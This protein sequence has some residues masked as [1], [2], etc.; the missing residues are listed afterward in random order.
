M[1]LIPIHD[2]Q[3]PRVADYANIRE[4]R[5]AH[6]RGVFIAEGVEVVR[7]LVLKSHFGAQSL[8]VLEK[9]LGAIADVMGAL[10]E[11]TPVYVASAEVMNQVVGFNIHRGCLAAGSRACTPSP[12][13]L[14]QGLGQQSLVVV[15]EGLANHDNVGG[16]F[17]N[18]A[19]FGA[20]AIFLDPTCADPL[21][22]KSIRTSMGGT[23]RVPFARLY[24]WPDALQQLTERG[25]TTYALSPRSDARSLDAL[26]AP[27]EP[28]PPR[29]ALLVGTEGPGLS[30]AAFGACSDWL[31]IP[32]APGVDSLNASTATGIA[33]WALRPR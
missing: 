1:M 29:R 12:Q 33:L 18:A 19:C 7:T 30:E 4:S 5:L 25:Y 14:L 9:R 11:E 13:S 8:F 16:I 22:R 10:P 17:R 3:D 28:L 31:R 23:L 26:L 2:A 20:E 15:M 32:M 6:E 21:Y 27:N 24:P